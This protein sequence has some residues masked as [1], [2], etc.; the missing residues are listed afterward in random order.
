MNRAGILVAVLLAIVSCSSPNR[1]WWR[2]SFEG[3]VAGIMEFSINSRGTRATG[4]VTGA[5]S[6]GESFRAEF[7]GT[8]SQG[9]L[10]A[11]L[12][13]SSD[14]DIGLRA[15]FLGL[16]NKSDRESPGRFP[17]RRFG[18]ALRVLRV[19]SAR[20]RPAAGA[21]RTNQRRRSACCS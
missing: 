14:T 19:P 4:K 15:G 9:Y 13:G 16:S 2:G 20:I 18:T 3:D 6:S 17:A 12:V 11:D 1:G 21:A 7:E 10:H 8:L 5:L